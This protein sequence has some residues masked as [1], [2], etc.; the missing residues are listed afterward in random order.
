MAG[1][2]VDAVQLRIIERRGIDVE[3]LLVDQVLRRVSRQSGVMVV[4]LV[5]MWLLLLMVVMMMDLIRMSP[6]IRVRCS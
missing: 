2:R 5:V 4:M 1:P 3:E 6:Q